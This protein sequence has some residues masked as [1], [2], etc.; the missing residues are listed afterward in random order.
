M[1]SMEEE[2][3]KK[4]LWLQQP[5]TEY[6]PLTFPERTK[7]PPITPREPA[8][9]QQVQAA[10]ALRPPKTYVVRRHFMAPGL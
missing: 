10:T 7:D 2:P 3:S 8:H 4:P 6:S 9:N 5:E 1:V